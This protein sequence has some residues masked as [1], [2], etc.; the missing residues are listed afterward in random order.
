MPRAD[1]LATF[2]CQFSKNSGRLNFLESSGPVEVHNRLGLHTV[3]LIPSNVEVKERAELCFFS[4]SG[5]SWPL[6]GRTSVTWLRLQGLVLA[7]DRF[8]LRIRE[9]KQTTLAENFCDSCIRHLHPV[10]TT[11]MGGAVTSHPLFDFLTYP[12]A[13][14]P[15]LTFYLIEERLDNISKPATTSLF[16]DL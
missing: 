7:L 1:N 9:G 5:L 3:Y 14:L 2:M 11:I 13:G 8:G 16:S 15:R 6:L 10:Q 4:P 12:G